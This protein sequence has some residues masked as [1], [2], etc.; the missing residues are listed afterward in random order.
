[1]AEDT[2]EQQDEAGTAKEKKPLSPKAKLIIW[3]V[4]G[5]L[6]FGGAIAGT[7]M[8]LGFFDSPAVEE[9]AAESEVVETVANKPAPAMYFPIKPA[10]VINFESKGRQRFLQVEV[11][12]LTREMNVFNA[13]QS[14]GPLV[15]NRL[16]MLFSGEI[17]EELQTNE[18]KELLRQKAL[19]ALQELMQQEVGNSGIEEVLFTSFV[20]Q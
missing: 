10:F 4:A 3:V 20:M 18:G 1:M 17:Y 2:E 6:L 19:A 14:H 12:V 8:M 11:S 5:L 9:V 13:L 7:L 15:K 16:V